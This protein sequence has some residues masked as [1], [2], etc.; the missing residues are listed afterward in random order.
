MTADRDLKPMKIR[1]LPQVDGGHGVGCAC[2]H[3][4]DGAMPELDVQVIPHAIRHASIFGA[5]DSIKAGYG[6][7]IRANHDPLPLLTQLEQRAPG[8]FAIEYLDRGPDTF[9]LRFVRK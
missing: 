3:E 9:R 8:A 7:I 1:E 2:G 5:L 4:D 6:M